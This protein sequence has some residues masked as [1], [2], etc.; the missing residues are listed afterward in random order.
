MVRPGETF[1]PGAQHLV[2][3]SRAV[4]PGARTPL[5]PSGARGGKCG[6]PPTRGTGGRTTRLRSRTAFVDV[7]GGARA[8]PLRDPGP[9][10]PRGPVSRSQWVTFSGTQR[11]KC[12]EEPARC[13]PSP[14]VSPGRGDHSGRGRRASSRQGSVPAIPRPARGGPSGAGT[15]LPWRRGPGPRP[16]PLGPSLREAH[17]QPPAPVLLAAFLPRAELGLS[18]IGLGG[19]REEEEEEEG[20]EGAGQQAEGGGEEPAEPVRRG[21]PELGPEETEQRLPAGSAPRRRRRRV[22]QDPSPAPQARARGRAPEGAAKKLGELGPF[23]CGSAEGAPAGGR[24]NRG[25]D[26]AQSE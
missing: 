14:G 13:V 19:Q 1:S 23:G 11:P 24:G 8:P 16:S 21:D 18:S 6:N 10:A 3:A 22:S 20:R 12:L 25:E 2:R 17:A 5:L 9:L 26:R 15:Q 7:R 4:P